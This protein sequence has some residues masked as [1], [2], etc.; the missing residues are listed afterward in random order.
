MAEGGAGA[1]AW[2]RAH[3]RVRGR[4]KVRLIESMADEGPGE[5]YVRGSLGGMYGKL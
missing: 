3:V 1:G 4:V 2:S 5:G